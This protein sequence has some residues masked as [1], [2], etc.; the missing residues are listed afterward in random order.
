[1]S[2]LTNASTNSQPIWEVTLDQGLFKARVNTY[3][4]NS[5]LGV[6][7]L[8]DKEGRRLFSKEVSVSY[9]APMGPD[10]LDVNQWVN[11]TIT[12]IDGK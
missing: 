3:L 6:L 12:W 7:T 4:D 2:N 9:G 8:E 10:A 11:Q 5:Y 1:M